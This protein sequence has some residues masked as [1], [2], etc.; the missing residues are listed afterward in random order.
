VHPV[1]ASIAEYAPVEQ[2]VH[3]VEPVDEAYDPAG[4]PAHSEAPLPALCL[5]DAQGWQAALL[6]LPVP[7]M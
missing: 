3:V 2:L 7:A 5:P 6:M 4:Q 1:E